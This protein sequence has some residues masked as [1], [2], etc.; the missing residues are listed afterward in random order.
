MP[1][2]IQ[3]EM[4]EN[5]QCPGCI[6]G[7]NTQCGSFDMLDDSGMVHCKKWRPS[8]FLGRV[9]R[10]VLGLPKGFTRT[11]SV[12]FGDKPFTYIRL[13]E[14]PE[15]MMKYD[16]FNVAVWAMEQDGYLFVRCY[17]PRNNWLFVDVI[18]DGK[19]EHVPGAVNVGD[20]YDEI[21]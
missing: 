20:F 11:G 2:K 19:M 1:N 3:L 6:L 9:G 7:G 12:E 13:Y 16:K 17:S 5:F 15:K 8:T 10:I 14:S 4:I 18:K 21:D